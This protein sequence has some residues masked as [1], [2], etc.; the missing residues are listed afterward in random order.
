VDLEN[1]LPQIIVKGL[2]IGRESPFEPATDVVESFVDRDRSGPSSL[3]WPRFYLAR[4][5]ALDFP[6]EFG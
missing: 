5:M 1:A 4:A 2:R 6:C 3:S